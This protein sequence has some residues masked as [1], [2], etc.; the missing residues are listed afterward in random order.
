[1]ILKI[2]IISV[3]SFILLFLSSTTKSN[4][5]PQIYVKMP[6]AFSYGK[7]LGKSDFFLDKRDG[8]RYK[9]IVIG[10]QVWMAENL[11]FGKIVFNLKQINKFKIIASMGCCMG[12][13]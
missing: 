8:R 10:N 11:N 6:M 13:L 3:F 2:K 9:K 1:M 4:H 5:K 12:C 7:L